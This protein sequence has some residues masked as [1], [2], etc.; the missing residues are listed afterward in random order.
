MS[1]TQEESQSCRRG[2]R[3]LSSLITDPAKKMDRPDMMGFEGAWQTVIVF[4]VVVVVDICR[5]LLEDIGDE[6]NLETWRM[7]EEVD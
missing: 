1:S 3:M 7:D 4:V 5:F 2:L 6:Y